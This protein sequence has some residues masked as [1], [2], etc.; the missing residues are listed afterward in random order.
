MSRRKTIVLWSALALIVVIVVMA[1]LVVSITQTQYGQDQ[2]RKYVQSWINGKVRGSFY[3]GRISGGLFGGVTIDSIEIRDENDSLFLRSGPVR[4]KYDMRDLFDRRIL[5]SYVDIQRPVVRIEE[6]SDGKLNYQRIFP[7]G[8]KKP[9][10]APR[11]FGDFIVIDSANIHDGNVAVGLRWRPADSLR[12][13]KRDSAIAYALGSFTRNSPGNQWR[14]EIRRTS[15]GFT[16]IRRFSHLQASLGYARISDPDSMGRFFRVTRAS[17]DSFDPPLSVKRI[18]G[19]VRHVGDTIWINSPAFQLPASK[20]R[21]PSGKL[22]WGSGIPMR[23]DI[24]I[25]G[26]Q[27]AMN[28]IAW[29]YPTLPTTG[30]GRLDLYINNVQHPRVMDYAVKKMDIRTTGSH[31]MGDMTY[32]VGGP[33]LVLKDVNLRA[34]PLDFALIRV[35]NGKPFPL[36]WKGQITGFARGPG[37]PLNR[38]KVSETQFTFADGNVPGAVSRGSARGELDILYP[39]FTVFR[40]FDVNLESLDLRTMQALSPAFL[41]LKGTVSGTT[42]LDDSWLDV[43]FSNADLVHHDAN[44]PTSRITGSGRITTHDTYMSYDLD[45]QGTPLNMT[46]L[47]NSYP[48][49]PLRGNYS[50]PIRIIGQPVNLGVDMSLTGAGGTITY[51]GTVDSNLPTYGAHGTGTVASLDLRTLLENPKAPKTMLAGDYFIDFV[52]D[53]LVVGTGTLGGSM[54]GTIDRLKISSSR[55][56]VRLNNGVALIDTLIVASDVAHANA[57]GS[58]GLISGME[59]RLAFNV[60]IDSLADVKRYIGRNSNIATDSLQGALRVAGELKGTK[61]LLSLEGTMSGRE[62]FVGGRSVERITGKFAL[63]GLPDKPA[64]QIEFDADTI[65]AGAF[66]FTAL[67]ATADVQSAT[68]ALF[69]AVLTSEGGV[70]SKIG[71]AA[72][73]AGDTTFVALDSGSVT[74]S[75]GSSYMLESPA[76]AML[77]PGGGSL[78]SL[79]LRHSS[80]ARLAI[81]DVRLTGDSVKGNLRTDSV[82]LGVL[83]AFVP[84]FQKAHG[85]LVANVDVRGTVKQP[86]IDGQ[87]RIKNGSASLTNVGL[88]VEKVN[89]DV[90]L[91]RDTVFIQRMSAETSRDRRGTLG[92][93]GFVSLEEYT[94]PVF[95]LR[96]QASDFHIVEKPGFASLD[97]STDNDLTLTGPFKRATV[98]G[99]VRVD[100]GTIFIPELLTKQLVDLSDPEFAGIVDTLLARD[101]KLLPE[102]PSDFARNLT[103]ENVA[104]NIGDAVWLRSSEA[105]VKLGGSLNVTLGRSTRTG[106]RSQLAL[107]GTL[108]AVRGTYR[109]TLVDPFVQPT[110]DVESGSLRFFGTPDLNPTLDIRAIHTIRQPT[111][112]TANRRDIRVRVNIAG[113][114]AHP[115]LTLD[116]PDNLPLSQS[117]LLSYLITGEPS[118]ALDNTQGLY[119][120]QLASFALRYGSTLLTSAIPRNLVDIVEIQTGRINDARAAQT[121][122]PYLYSLLNSRAI[123]GKQIGSNWFLGLSTGLCFVNANN[124]KDNFGLKLEYRF[125]SIYTAQAGIEPGSSDVTCARNA[126]QIQQQTPRQLGFDFF[127][128]WR[129]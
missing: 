21:M 106:E 2:V 5:L 86:I 103:L 48:D 87:F 126:P 15:E 73:R 111:Q 124:F 40:G 43:R 37:G 99:A 118:I 122:D 110:F 12:G 66:G 44:L 50:G 10:G 81:R 6:H 128:T 61:D 14:T 107:E 4:V 68:Q 71:G 98:T 101:R 88:N 93:T 31:L 30:G 120:S 70:V 90:L 60:S 17:F 65:R 119:R 38:F 108:N 26:D 75:S 82:D 41:A 125:N 83:E 59:G 109:L 129:F 56:N 117:D 42:H 92:V 79:I 85:T 16:H 58:V 3:V 32:G 9:P 84:G 54:T 29:I 22:V 39:A 116:N 112:T 33:V 36:P 23:Y 80:T 127:R 96:M 95:N 57:S 121:A 8:P 74:V 20:G 1:G 63:A 11:G 100:R 114:L 69:N 97:I 27:V 123:V 91:E 46:T 25:I 7:S 47:A 19:D 51:K 55:A 94:N 45:L 104:V 72:R 28:D 13:Y 78:D 34:A 62:L 52:G 113:T 115:T 67:K 77:L 89:A 64:G 53:S 24:H 76:N 18:A 49:I 35:F 102:T 105:N